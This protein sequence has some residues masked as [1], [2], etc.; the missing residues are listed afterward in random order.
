[1]RKIFLNEDWSGLRALGHILARIASAIAMAVIGA[2]TTAFFCGIATIFVY[3][4]AAYPGF[5]IGFVGG[6]VVGWKAPSWHAVVVTFAATI[7]WFAANLLSSRSEMVLELQPFT[8]LAGFSV[9]AVV[10][11]ASVRSV[12]RHRHRAIPPVIRP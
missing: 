5:A 10:S 3:G 11:I 7:G 6:A 9:F 8:N 2:A 4:L 1:M 12:E